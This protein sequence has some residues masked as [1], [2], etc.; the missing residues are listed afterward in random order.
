M[1]KVIAFPTRPTQINPKKGS[2]KSGGSKRPP[3]GGENTVQNVVDV[4]NMLREQGA[5]D[6]RSAERVLLGDMISS[7]VVLPKFGLV[8]VTVKDVDEGGLAFEMGG[9]MGSYKQGEQ[10]EM[11]FYLNGQTYFRVDV[12]VA[13]SGFDEGTGVARHGARFVKDSLNQ[14]A[15][16][17]FV[18]FLRNVSVSLR[19][20]RGERIVSNLTS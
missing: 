18:Q 20:D 10:V 14:E 4:T 2:K 19:T 7:H 3:G 6:R 17:H 13:Y 12:E 16:H 9:Y 8:Q 11:R 15:L 5:Q 1:G